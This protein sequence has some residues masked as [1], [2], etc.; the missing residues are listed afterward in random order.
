MAPSE[1]SNASTGPVGSIAAAARSLES[2]AAR[3]REFP[4]AAQPRP[5][6]LTGPP[7]GFGALLTEEATVAIEAGLLGADAS[8]PPDAVDALRRAGLLRGDRADSAVR[9]TTALASSMGFSTDRGGRQLPS[10]L[11]SISGVDGTSYVMDADSQALTYPSEPITATHRPGGYARLL[12]DGLTVRVDF[13]PPWQTKDT[14]PTSDAVEVLETDAA[15]AFAPG[16]D[17]E[18]GIGLTFRLSAPLGARVL[19]EADGAPLVVARRKR[20]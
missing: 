11:L 1:S 15:V 4:V 2:A 3:W 19:C 16:T 10:W 14:D 8:L 9:V 17:A 13:A 7:A 5:I 20:R 6:V 12:G 18:S